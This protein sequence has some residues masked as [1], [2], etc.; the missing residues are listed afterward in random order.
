MTIDAVSIMTKLEDHAMVLGVFERVNLHEPKNAP[1]SGITCA[2]WSDWMGPAPRNSGL[3]ATS[4]LLIFNVRIY[5]SMLSEPQDYIDPEIIKAVDLLM[6]A[7]SGDFELGGTVA[8]ID[9]LGQSGR[10]MQA[11]AG[12]INQDGKPLRVMTI[13]LPVVLNDVWEQ[14]R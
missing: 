12:Y 14:A 5:S 1:G 4:A 11:Q 8:W 9:L 10:Q 3:S 2:V 7:Y 13:T 6:G